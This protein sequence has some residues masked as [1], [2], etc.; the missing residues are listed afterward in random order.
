MDNSGF[1]PDNN[2]KERDNN[3]K[4]RDNNNTRRYKK[5]FNKGG[6]GAGGFDVVKKS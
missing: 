4:E 3:R 2:R 1:Q 5:K 6:E